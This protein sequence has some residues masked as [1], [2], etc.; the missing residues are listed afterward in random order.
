MARP[1]GIL[2]AP[3]NWGSMLGFYLQLH[4]GLA[5][6]N[7]YRAEQDPL[8]SDLLAAEGYEIKNGF[9]SVSDAPGFGFA[10]DE[11]RFERVNVNFELRA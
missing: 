11:K 8:T 6:S 5:V 3:H 1:Q 10:L 2:I 9:C 4:V 7:F